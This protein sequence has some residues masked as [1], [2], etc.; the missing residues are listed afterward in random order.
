MRFY[1]IDALYLAWILPVVVMFFWYSWHKR[2]KAMAMLGKSTIIN[3]MVVGASL[4]RVLL[5]SGLFVG[6]I[7]LVVFAIA[8]PSWNLIPEKVKSRGRDVIFLLDVSRSMLATD[9]IPNRLE[10]SKLAVKDCLEKIKG[11]RVG[12]VAFA[13][14]TVIKCPLT[15][16][17][18]FFRMA[19]DELS[20]D[21]VSRGGTMIGDAIRKCLNDVFDKKAVKYRDIILITDG[22]DHD[23]LP[24]NAAELA[25]KAGVRLIIIG[26]GDEKNGK[27]IPLKDENG[28]KYFLKKKDGSEVWTKLNANVLRKMAKASKGGAYFNVATGM[29]DLGEVYSRLIET[30]EKNEYEEKKVQRFEEKFQIFLLLAVVLLFAELLVLEVRKEGPKC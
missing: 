12:L 2:R 26:I 19:I 11:D 28:K 22:E 25:G 9:L 23:S 6:A 13:G 3:D 5:K 8:R 15:L 17:Y 1:N 4:R 21:S 16:D 7:F 30:A 27:R 10:R 18:G 14:N 20:P 24:V 29:I